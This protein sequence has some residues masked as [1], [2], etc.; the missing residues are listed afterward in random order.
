MDRYLGLQDL[1]IFWTKKNFE[2]ILVLNEDIPKNAFP[3]NFFW[4]FSSFFANFHA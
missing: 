3:Q 2:I 1:L 4:N